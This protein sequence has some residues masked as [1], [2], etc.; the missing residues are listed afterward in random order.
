MRTRVAAIIVG[1]LAAAAPALA[2]VPDSRKPIDATA[3]KN[4]VRSRAAHPYAAATAAVATLNSQRAGLVNHR[5]GARSVQK[6]SKDKDIAAA[7]ALDGAAMPVN[8]SADSVGWRLIEDPATGAR[9][10]LPEKLVP[11]ADMSRIGSRWTSAQGQIQIETFRLTEA[12]LPALFEQEKKTSRRE[13]VSSALESDSFVITGVQGLKNFLVRATARGSEV[14]G[15]TVLYDQA[16][17]G[18]MYRVAAAVV[19]A[20]DGFPDPQSAPR[21]GI[22]RAVEYGTAIVVGSNGYLIAPNRL[23]DECQVITLPGLGHAERIAADKTNGLALLRLYG[24][25]GLVPAVLSGEKSSGAELKLVGVAAP[26]AQA[27]AAEVTSASARL[28][29][30]NIEPAPNA[31]F[32][33]A[34]AVDA[35]GALVGMVDLKPPVVAGNGSSGQ[36]AT[37]VPVGKVRAFLEEHGVTPAADAPG[38]APIEQSVVRVICVR[39]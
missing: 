5:E 39:K 38:N 32:S 27:G 23:A 34:A 13:I 29:A 35:V 1:L 12:A 33:G 16:T 15:V 8:F 6:Q 2:Q 28:I 19:G 26:V 10:G 3:H 18:T 25:H 20:F 36:V 9:L 14:R 17:E 4:S 7:A 11:R 21:A 31:G 22:R 30:Q 24:A 37:L